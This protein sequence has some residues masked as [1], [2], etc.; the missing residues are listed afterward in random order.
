MSYAARGYFT[1]FVDNHYPI[2]QL[3]H[4]WTLSLT[5][6]TRKIHRGYSGGAAKSGDGMRSTGTVYFCLVY[7][8]V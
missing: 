7:A 4:Y 6:F 2:A 5:D 1:P 8:L 3:N